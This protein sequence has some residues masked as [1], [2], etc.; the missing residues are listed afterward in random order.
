[1]KRFVGTA[2][3]LLLWLTSLSATPSP[4]AAPATIQGTV[5]SLQ[6]KPASIDVVTGVGMALRLVRVTLPPAARVAVSTGGRMPARGAE[7]PWTSLRRGDIVRI[8]VHRTGT[9]LVADHIEK[10]VAR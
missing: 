4:Q 5:H 9:S 6:P 2:L 1:M 7:V 8:Q 3:L 10:V